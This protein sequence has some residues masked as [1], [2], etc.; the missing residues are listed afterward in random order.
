MLL[1]NEYFAEFLYHTLV[2]SGPIPT[3]E[4]PEGVYPYESFCETSKRPIIKK[5]R[6]LSIENEYLKVEICPDLGGKVHSIFHK[7]SQKEVLYNPGAIRASRILPRMAFIS[8]GIEVSFPISH[9]PVQLEKVDYIAK[10]LGDRAYIWCGER[11]L[12][13]GMQWTVEYSLGTE[14]EFL[15]QRTLFY[16]QTSKSHPWMSWSN[17]ALEA[18]EDTEMYFP[19]GEVLYHG[20][21]LKTIDWLQ[22]GPKK[23]SHINR[24]AGFFWEKAEYN[25]FGVFTPSLGY[26]LYHIADKAE[27]PGIKLWVYGKG[28]DET[29]AH[30]SGLC[31]Q[32]YLEIQAGPIKDQSIKHDLVPGQ[33]HVHTEY[34]LPTDKPIDLSSL[35][36]FSPALID[37]S[38]I[39]LFDWI[40]RPK[41]KVWLELLNAYEK[42]NSE[43][44]PLPPEAFSNE[45]PPC[46]I[47]QLGSAIKWAIQI[48]QS[49]NHELWKYYLA[50]WY[51]GCAEKELALLTLANTNL[52]LARVL[53]ARL[54]RC[55]NQDYEAALK[56]ILSVY[57]SA[58][59]Y[60][61]QVVIERDIILSHF[62][63]KFLGQREYWLKQVNSLKDDGL[64]ERMS[65]YLFDAGKLQEAKEMLESA[66]FEPIHQRYERTKL[67][68][69]LKELLDGEGT[70]PPESLGEDDLAVFGAYRVTEKS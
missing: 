58:I 25:T 32:S 41:T 63:D 46:G 42:Q 62:K 61:P 9:T 40:D 6:M 14:D 16:N 35:S 64:I 2:S 24:M 5:F 43:A 8:G 70:A 53:E 27:M 20:D 57:S 50:V 66:K 68:K 12:R 29:W 38:N 13:Y 3:I 47:E 51:A 22:D 69:K 52:D 65:Y 23:L 30:L 7:R 21:E 37:E 17:A 1:Q 18:H 15:T 39:P 44:V 59:A 54:L 19:K 28:K 10:T 60:H 36:T 26:G 4:D 49:E 33:R 11:E 45:W 67:W 48:S 34:W 56:A 55:L 31:K